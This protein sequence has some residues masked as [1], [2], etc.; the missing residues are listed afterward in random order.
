[1]LGAME[2]DGRFGHVSLLAPLGLSLGIFYASAFFPFIGLFA[3]APLYYSMVVFGQ[4]TGLY[5]VLIAV[6]I[7]FLIG[8]LG[9][10]AVFLV[11]CGLVSLAL[12]YAYHNRLSLETTFAC[13]TLAPYAVGAAIVFAASTMS[14][15]NITEMLTGWGQEAITSM[16]DSYKSINA[17][18]EVT[19]WLEDS[20]ALLVDGFVRVFPSLAFISAMLMVAINLLAIRIFSLK[21]GWDF[22]FHGHALSRWISPDWFVWIVVA[23]GFGALLSDG[24]FQSVSLNFLIIAGAVYVIQGVAVIHFFFLKSNIPV[25][26]VAIGYFLFFSQPIL[27]AGVSALGIADLWVDFRKLRGKAGDDG[28]SETGHD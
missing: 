1:M 9:Q 11:S 24:F 6:V 17:D 16:T 20:S 21:T 14:G 4:K 25:V 10:S 27:L 2:K 18:E 28:E 26:L 12:S 23:G 19:A 15:V 7:T 5:L 22:H 3:P 13:A 8:G